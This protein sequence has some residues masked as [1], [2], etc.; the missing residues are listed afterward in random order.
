MDN[1]KSLISGKPQG[2]AL[3]DD[4]IFLTSIPGFNDLPEKEK[5][6]FSIVELNYQNYSARSVLAFALS[7]RTNPVKRGGSSII[8]SAIKIK[9]KITFSA[10]SNMR[11]LMMRWSFRTFGRR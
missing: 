10:E 9:R 3:L 1:N 7:M 6:R 4:R 5:N 2:T 11:I 8:G